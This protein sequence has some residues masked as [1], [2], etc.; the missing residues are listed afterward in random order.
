[1]KYIYIFTLL[2]TTLVTFS[3]DEKTVTLVTSGTGSTL[4]Q[5]TQNALRSAIEQAF[6]VFISSSTKILNDQI[7]KDEI[8]SISNGNIKEYSILSEVQTPDG[9]WSSLI[10]AVVSVSK[11][12]SFCEN[13]GIIV[14]FKGSL[15]AYNVNQQILN[16]KNEIKA[17]EDLCQIIKKNADVSFNY[18]LTAYDPVSINTSNDQWRVPMYISVTKND[19]FENIPALLY[20][21]L[22]GLSLSIEEAN[23]YIQLGKNVYPIC[24]AANEKDYSYILL[25]AEKS[26]FH[27]LEM[28]YYFNHS[29]QNFR[30]SNGIAQWTIKDKPES[31]KY[32]YDYGFRVLIKKINNGSGLA[33]CKASIFYQHCSPRFNCNV[34]MVKELDDVN[35]GNCYFSDAIR[36]LHVQR[37]NN[38]DDFQTVL[39]KE[40]YN[41]PSHEKYFTNQFLFVRNLKDKVLNNNTGLIISFIPHYYNGKKKKRKNFAEDKELVRFYYEDIRSLNEINKIS[42]YSVSPI[43][44]K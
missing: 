10:K 44:N 32:I 15:F 28:L 35:D 8:V 6:G 27:L 11:L 19:N 23:N 34:G 31:L 42:E 38:I 14:E 43:G 29:L 26:I 22:K 25:R 1:M 5:A 4:E 17:I 12:T 20:S 37:V 2:I 13:R 7:V 33:Y 30:I 40:R 18:S 16:E 21:S 9:Q 3:Q 24:I 36:Y 41:D 39:E